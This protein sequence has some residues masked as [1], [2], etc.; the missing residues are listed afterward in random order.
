MCVSRNATTE[1]FRVITMTHV[2]SLQARLFS[3]HFVALQ[4]HKCM[5]RWMDGRTEDNMGMLLLI[6]KFGV[7]DLNKRR[8][9]NEENARCMESNLLT[10]TLL[11]WRIW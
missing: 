1:Q 5:G 8:R 10:L 4:V 9:R 6:M 7:T 2:V 3:E 11:T